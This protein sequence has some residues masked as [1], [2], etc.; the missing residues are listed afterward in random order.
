VRL[1]RTQRAVAA[2]VPP[3]VAAAGDAEV[4]ALEDAFDIRTAREALADPAPSIP[5]AEVFGQYRG[6]LAACPGDD[7]GW[8]LDTR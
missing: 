8:A 1:S 2:I 6:D 5:L 4:A 3:E 7:E